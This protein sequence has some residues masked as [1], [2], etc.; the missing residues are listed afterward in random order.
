MAEEKKVRGK[1]GMYSE[2]GNKEVEQ[3]IIKNKA[4]RNRYDTMNYVDNL[5]MIDLRLL[6][7]KKNFEEAK[8]DKVKFIVLN[9]L[10]KRV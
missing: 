2:E 6:A 1:Y 10:R 9:E 5:A 8:D 3:I 7:Q 4:K